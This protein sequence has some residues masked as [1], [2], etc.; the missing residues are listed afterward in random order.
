MS[1]G[2]SPDASCDTHA[3][4]TSITYITNTY[5]IPLSGG[6]Y[7][8][9][10]NNVT[11]VGKIDASSTTVLHPDFDISIN[12]DLADLTGL[13]SGIN[14][15]RASGL[16]KY[17]LHFDESDDCIKLGIAGS[18]LPVLTRDVD[19]SMT[20]AKYLT[21]D[22]SLLK[23]KT[24]TY[25]DTEIGAMKTKTDFLTLSDTLN[26][27]GAS[28]L[29]QGLLTTSS[30]TFAGL[31]T[32]IHNIT[33]DADNQLS[34]TRAGSAFNVTLD[35]GNN[36][37]MGY[38]TGQ[39][40]QISNTNASLQN[41][42]NV[43]DA[44][45]NGVV[46]G[47]DVSSHPFVQLNGNGAGTTPYMDWCTA[48][49]IDYD[50][51]FMMTASRT[52]AMVGNGGAM[53]L[54]VDGAVRVPSIATAS[55]NLSIAPAT[56]ITD[57]TGALNLTNTAVN[58]LR[59][60]YD[61][62]NY[63]TFTTDA[64]GILT[65]GDSGVDVVKIGIDVSQQN[66]P[67]SGSY[68]SITNNMIQI[69]AVGGAPLID[70]TSSASTD[71]DARIILRSANV[72]GL[73]G[74]NFEIANGFKVTSQANLTL[75]PATAI[76]EITGALNVSTDITATGDINIGGGNL[77]HTSD[78]F[79]IG[80]SGQPNITMTDST[81]VLSIGASTTF[82][83]TSDSLLL[84]DADSTHVYFQGTKDGNIVL[85]G[86]VNGVN[87]A[88]L[89]GTALTL[90]GNLVI[91]NS[92][93]IGCVAD[94]DLITLAS[95]SI[96]IP[97]DTTLHIDTIAE[98]TPDNGVIVE[99]LT[100]KDTTINYCTQVSRSGTI[101]IYANDVDSYAELHAS[102]GASIRAYGSTTDKTHFDAGHHYFYQGDSTT[103]IINLSSTGLE[104]SA[105]KH[106]KE[107][108]PTYEDFRI[109][110][111]AVTIPSTTCP[112]WETALTYLSILSFAIG[113]NVSFSVQM[114]HS[115]QET[116][117]IKPHVHMSNYVGTIPSGN[118]I[119]FE[120]IY[121]WANI[122][123]VFPAGSII[124]AE[125]TAGAII[126]ADSHI[127]ADFNDITASGKTVSSMLNCR[128]RR[129]SATTTD[130]AGEVGLLE[131]DFHYL[132]DKFGHD[133]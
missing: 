31:G 26:V 120:L 6:A 71:Y 64:N 19:G 106:I 37:K 115:W 81:N 132:V 54:D 102:S 43:S 121:S 38:T 20:N 92:G 14:F 88:T 63:D 101:Q 3:N 69:N 65:I 34:L 133:I 11:N 91:P 113:D 114:P 25:G 28:S 49:N 36:V 52:M 57:L 29:N 98:T 60:N 94:S 119:K 128:L 2:I 39:Q 100:L 1:L 27:T 129:V 55:G 30:P 107:L 78:Q 96:T 24:S 67:A 13:T 111:N 62:S 72:L 79:T 23:G 131:A 105:G 95:T 68:V 110:A 42:P 84:K 22:S 126:T 116:T 4:P 50:M 87:S 127:V 15:N 35:S 90:T 75:E 124:N 12:S 51:R 89:S 130:Y 40:F 82:L 118:Q 53:T 80:K 112:S 56:S 108:D 109:P 61:G 58:Q 85:R 32:G 76:T 21:W 66:S 5:S 59:V 46:V 99:G 8:F 44:S 41:S 103:E 33:A 117:A 47:L 83:T 122:D 45:L 104:I 123:G 9:G 93:T 86:G 70:F 97:T 18:E 125:Y 74:A 77:S 10:G 17:R 16:T 48:Q 73:D 7:D